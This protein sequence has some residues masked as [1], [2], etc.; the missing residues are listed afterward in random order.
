LKD[1]EDFLDKVYLPQQ[2]N[3]TMFTPQGEILRI[4]DEFWQKDIKAHL[5]TIKEELQSRSS[6]YKYT[7]EKEISSISRSLG[8]KLKRDK[9]GYFV[10]YN[11]HQL[12]IWR[13]RYLSDTQ[14]SDIPSGTEAPEDSKPISPNKADVRP[15]IPSFG[16]GLIDSSMFE[17]DKSKDDEKNPKIRK[18]DDDNFSFIPRIQLR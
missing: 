14:D 18:R 11:P 3:A 1:L 8:F 10:L 9:K 17:E 6:D 2:E 4:L 12:D 15:P 13:E 16:S 7:T 5:K